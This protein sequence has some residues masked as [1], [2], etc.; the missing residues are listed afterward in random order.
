MEN[1]IKKMM[2]SYGADLC[3]IA[4]IEDFAGALAG[5]SP[6]LIFNKC[7][8]VIVLELNFPWVLQR[9][10]PDWFMGTIFLLFSQKIP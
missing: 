8:S 6:A 2:R 9:L 4:G 5:F 3:G 7:K 1:D 10:I